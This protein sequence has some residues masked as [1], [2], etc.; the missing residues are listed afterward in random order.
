MNYCLLSDAM[1]YTRQT[2]STVTAKR[3]MYLIFMENVYSQSN[4]LIKP[5]PVTYEKSVHYKSARPK[6][7][8]IKQVL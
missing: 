4:D 7:Q 2:N 8:N 1:W 6:Q 3:L 5:L